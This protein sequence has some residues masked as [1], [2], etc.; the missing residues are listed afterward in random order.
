MTG[1]MKRCEAAMQEAAKGKHVCMVC[2]GDP[3]ILAMAGLILELRKNTAEFQNIDIQIHAGVTAANIAAA[4]L[5]APLQNG[6][7]SS[8]FPICLFPKKKFCKICLPRQKAPCRSAFIIP[9]EK[10]AG[11]CSIKRLKFSLRNAEKAHC[12]LM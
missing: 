5:G 4:S 9:Q 2:S 8:A 1:E 7:A 11:N 3:G 12:A 10:N 6:F